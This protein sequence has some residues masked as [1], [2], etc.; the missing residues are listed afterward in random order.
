MGGGAIESLSV[1]S[2]HDGS[3]IAFRLTWKDATEDKTTDLSNRFVDAVALQLPLKVEEQP[4]FMM[5]HQGARVNIWRWKAL[6]QEGERYPK[7]YADDYYRDAALSRQLPGFLAPFEQLVAE[8][9]GSLTRCKEQNLEGSAQWQKGEWSVVLVRD[10]ASNEG[11]V[12][13]PGLESKIAFA[14]WDG[15]A[16]ER[17]GQKSLTQWIDFKIEAP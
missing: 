6:T 10:F 2:L 7:S 17:N 11:A 4:T 14:V 9:F 1:Q 8:G 3:R 12:L 15:S 13:K 5:G 16:K